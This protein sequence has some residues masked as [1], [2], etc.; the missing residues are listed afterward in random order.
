MALTKAFRNTVR[1]RALKDRRFR[2]ALL[3]EAL[4]TL[5]EGDLDTGKAILRNYINAT[6]GF[7][8][9]ADEVQTPSKSL[10]R[11]LGPSGN[12]RAENLLQVIAALQRAEKIS[13][14]VVFR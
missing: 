12:P 9:L 1:A 5:M 6:L 14:E 10:H 7:E 3:R 4:S 13:A 8:Q 2:R 11:M